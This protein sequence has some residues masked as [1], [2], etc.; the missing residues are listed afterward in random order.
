[1]ETKKELFEMKRQAVFGQI[2]SLY[3][4]MELIRAKMR[5]SKENK[6]KYQAALHIIEGYKEKLRN[7]LISE[8]ERLSHTG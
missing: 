4:A 7:D 3:D 6:K 1:M 8:E 5:T 2:D